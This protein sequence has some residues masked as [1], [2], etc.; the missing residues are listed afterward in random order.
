MLEVGNIGDY[1][2]ERA[3]FG[4]WCIVSAPL[5]LGF[6]L[7]NQDDMN[8]VWDIITNLEAISVSQNWA[9]HP[10]ML[11]KSWDPQ[12]PGNLSY[13]WAVSCNP[14]DPQEAPWSYDSNTKAV[15][16]PNG[17]CLDATSP[18]ELTAR[19]CNGGSTQQ[20][21]YSNN[22][23]LASNGQCVDVYDFSGP[24]VQ[25]YSCNGGCNQ[26]FVFA[27]DKTLDDTCSP[28]L[29]LA[30]RP[31]APSGGNLMQIWAKPQ[32]KG[33][34]GVLVLNSDVN[35]PPIPVTI[36]FKSLNMTGT[37]AI[38]DI[39]LHKD[40]GTASN[41]FTT[42]PIAGHDSRFYLFSPTQADKE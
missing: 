6:D 41:S 21:G 29:C 26:K 38:H 28:K 36:D 27:S 24:V 39:W 18:S 10:G 33:A 40:L 8:R 4:A 35:D 23:L 34:M 1:N 13:L 17:L 42:D 16:S 3:H 32:P 37:L 25:L 11:V 22:N 20:F 9:G 15:K 5:I 30:V 19:P 14:S 7:T 31:D 12:P 2:T